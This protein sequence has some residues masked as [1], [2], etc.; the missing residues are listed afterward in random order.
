MIYKEG[1]KQWMSKLIDTY[2]RESK[3]QDQQNESRM[4]NQQK[5]DIMDYLG[6]HLYEVDRIFSGYMYQCHCEDAN[7]FKLA[8]FELYKKAWYQRFRLIKLNS[9]LKD[10][11][12]IPQFPPT[13]DKVVDDYIEKETGKRPTVKFNLKE[14]PTGNPLG[15]FA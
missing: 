5:V 13:F 10:L 12:Y 1:V 8:S 3:V 14:E 15:L 7:D 6:D 2:R 4:Y 11:T 9:Y